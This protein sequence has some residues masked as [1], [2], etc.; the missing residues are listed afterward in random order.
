VPWTAGSGLALVVLAT[1]H[2]VAQHFV[3]NQTGGLRTDAQ[4]LDYVANPAR[5][6]IECGFLFVVTI[7]AM[8]GVRSIPLDFDPGPRALP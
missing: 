8:L 2:M 1:A 5:F 3:V 4:V 7:H 6:I